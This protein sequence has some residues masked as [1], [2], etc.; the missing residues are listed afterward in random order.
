MPGIVLYDSH[1]LSLLTLL[2]NLEMG[3][4]IIVIL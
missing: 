2:L 3:T 1:V 4:I